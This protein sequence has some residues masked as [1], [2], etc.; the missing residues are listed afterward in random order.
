LTVE[1]GVAG[2]RDVELAMMTGA[3]LMP[4][5]FAR[6]DGEGLDTVLERL[7]T[8]FEEQDDERLAPPATLKR[9][10]AQ[11]RL[12][13]KS[14]QGFFPYPQ[15]GE[16]SKETV[17]LEWREGGIA[18]AWLNRPPANQVNAQMIEDLGAIWSEL[19]GEA[20]V[21]V[22]A[23]S[24]LFAFSGGADLK[25]FSSLED[26][27]EGRETLDA[28]HELMLAMERSPTVTIACVGG[29][30]YGAGCELTMACDVTIAGESARF[31]QPEVGLGLIPGLGGT[32]RLPRM[33]G[34]RRALEMNL[35]GEGISARAA[36]DRGLVNDVVADL[37][38][39]DTTLTWAR[40]LAGQPPIAVEHIK[41]ITAAPGLGEGIEA[42]KEGFVTAFASEDA[43]EGIGAFLEKRPPKFEGK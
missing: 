36:R 15:P 38:L 31:G 43:K 9:L 23:S 25:E 37:D 4:G 3:G 30:A 7:E 17:L 29:P 1:D 28:G 32:Q 26:P 19:D 18:I 2:A 8:A 40:K 24:T 42:E 34:R 10:V 16:G 22:L 5:P 27:E 20:R 35:V 6:A 21:L 41:R 39:F 11:G 12:G 13:Q 14:G 33:V